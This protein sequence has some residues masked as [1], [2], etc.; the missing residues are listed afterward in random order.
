MKSVIY[1]GKVYDV[2]DTNLPDEAKKRL[3]I[4]DARPAKAEKPKKKED[5]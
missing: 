4:K 5:K 3:G 2:S 1:K